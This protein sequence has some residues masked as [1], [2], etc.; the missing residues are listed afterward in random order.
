MT[1][2]LAP[3]DEVFPRIQ[4]LCDAGVD[5][6]HLDVMDGQFV[7]PI[8]FGAAFAARVAAMGTP[9]EAHLMTE[10]PHLHFDA[11]REAGC[12][13]IIFHYEATPHA[14][15]YCTALRDQGIQAGVA[16]NPGTDVEC[17]RPILEVLDLALVMT[18]N[19]GW[20][21]QKLIESC[22]QKCERL[23]GWAPDLEIEVD[24]G[25]DLTTIESAWQSGATTF[26]AGNYFVGKEIAHAVTELRIACD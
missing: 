20:G 13:R 6:I 15:R 26:V 12:K 17:L 18:V 16:I 4:E 24:G 8:T 14:H 11:F 22:L 3:S 19:P 5:W 2:K 9:V 10:T 23:R 1:L 25:I 21:G 7:P